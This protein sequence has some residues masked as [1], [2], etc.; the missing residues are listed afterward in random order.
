M[1]KKIFILFLLFISIHTYG[2]DYLIKDMHFYGLKNVS[3]NELIKIIPNFKGKKISKKEVN[4]I[5][6][7]IFHT[8]NFETVKVSILNNNLLIKLKELPV[9]SGIKFVGND[10]IKDNDLSK[11]AFLN[12]VIIGH[13]LNKA[14][15]YSFKKA[16]KILYF[17]IGKFKVS[18][19]T[20]LTKISKNKVI[21]KIFLEENEYSKIKKISFIGNIKFNSEKLISIFTSIDNQYWWDFLD[22]RIYQKKKLTKDLKNMRNFYLSNG[23]INY[24]DNIQLSLNN[25]KKDLYVLIKIQEGN[26]YKYS[27]FNIQIKNDKCNCLDKIKKK[28]KLKIGESYSLENVKKLEKN[29]IEE[30][31]KYGYI[32]SLVK[33]TSKINDKKYT[34][35]VK[36]NIKLSKKF[37]V[38]KI[39]IYGNQ[40]T[41]DDII[42]RE[43]LQTEGSHLNSRLIN[44]SKKHLKGTNY[45]DR[46]SYKFKN[47]KKIYN[48][49]DLNFFT[50]EKDTGRFGFG[51]GYGLDGKVSFHGTIQK[52]NIVGTGRNIIF[53][54]FKNATKTSSEI[55][56]I[57]PFFKFY[58][59]SSINRIFQDIFIAKKS[60]HEA[61]YNNKIY[62]IEKS[63]G[64]L[65]DE[66]TT[67]RIGIGYYSNN[68]FRVRPQIAVMRYLQKFGLKQAG[69][70]FS[71]TDFGINIGATYNSLDKVTFP[72]HGQKI[73][74]ESKIMLPF[75]DNKYYKLLI[76]TQKYIPLNEQ[77]TW[78]LY[79]R[80]RLGFGNGFKIKEMFFYENFYSNN[81]GM[82]RGFTNNSIG[83]KAVYFN[84]KKSLKCD[85]TM[86]Y[87]E[88]CLS[89]DAMGGNAIATASFSLITPNIFDN[90]QY[91]KDFR[92]SIFFDIGTVWDTRWTYSILS[93][94]IGVPNYSYFAKI[95]YSLG[96]S[97]MWMSPIGS[98]ELSYSLPLKKYKGDQ[99]EKLQVTLGKSW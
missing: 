34:V 92:T 96:A 59:L 32:N 79:F 28:F 95:R 66:Y 70:M 71:I 45:F 78:T 47:K 22:N 97:I 44:K 98:L 17:N 67:F 20:E 85:N 62:G 80:N 48:K 10:N 94:A 46:I 9:L 23:Y 82:L 14:N 13:K 43:F 63:L 57:N 21:L 51:L 24:K 75:S 15:V 54:S 5:I 72:R 64:L 52:D 87:N 88:L 81:F 1:D 7:I 19:K 35:D 53:N 25:N 41:Q 18:V 84:K 29:I 2:K 12:K 99:V 30:I 26:K 11:S 49:L 90:P 42:R 74:F 50:K 55:L 65:I 3:S 8:G 83:P 58:G 38:K 33:A 61:K 37:N 6:H 86:I 40:Q 27:H 31:N 73:N 93:K 36:I 39:N 60:D 56:L 16:I 77:S 76:D 4:K 69:K 89:D 68:L 91:S